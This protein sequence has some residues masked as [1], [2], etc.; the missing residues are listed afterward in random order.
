MSAGVVHTVS[1]VLPHTG[2]VWIGSWMESAALGASCGLASD[3][4]ML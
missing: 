2:S 4:V 1:S 3:F